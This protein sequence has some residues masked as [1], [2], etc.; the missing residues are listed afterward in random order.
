MKILTV[1][2]MKRMI[3]VESL[4]PLK[5]IH[6]GI[7]IVSNT[8]ITPLWFG[9]TL[10]SSLRLST[11]VVHPTER[12]RPSTCVLVFLLK[13]KSSEV[14][15]PGSFGQGTEHCLGVY[16]RRDLVL[17]SVWREKNV[18]GSLGLRRN[19]FGDPRPFCYLLREISFYNSKIRRLIKILILKILSE[20]E[21]KELC[22]FL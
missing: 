12:S 8:S 19:V 9:S 10:S 4:V 13:L 7:F 5:K 22:Y 3:S 21:L 14:S 20:R 18:H 1:W 15:T 11:H 17:Y 6:R 16:R 2:S